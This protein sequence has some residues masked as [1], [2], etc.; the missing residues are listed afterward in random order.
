MLA[1]YQIDSAN[2][3]K[4]LHTDATNCHHTSLVNVVTGLLA[5]NDECHTNGLEGAI[6]A[7][8]GTAEKSSRALL[9]SFNES[10]EL[11]NTR[12]IETE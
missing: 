2:A 10:S 11:L 1:A 12:R 3:L 9:Q 7:E 5:D 6:I 8:D 4:Q